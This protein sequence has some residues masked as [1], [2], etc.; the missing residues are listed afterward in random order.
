[1]NKMKEKQKLID[2]IEEEIEKGK[3]VFNKKIT[4]E[5]AV[6]QLE[7]LRFQ[8]LDQHL[9]RLN[10]NV[11][12]LIILMALFIVLQIVTIAAIL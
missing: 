12:T 8:L 5:E 2:Q 6:Y 11:F 9:R 10:M 4:S 7:G 1:M 3:G